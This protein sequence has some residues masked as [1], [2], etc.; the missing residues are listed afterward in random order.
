MLKRLIVHTTAHGACV[1]SRFAAILIA[2]CFLV[3]IVGFSSSLSGVLGISPDEGTPLPDTTIAPP[4][5][6]PT[7]GPEGGGEAIWPPASADMGATPVES[8]TEYIEQ[9]SVVLPGTPSLPATSGTPTVAT[10]APP[11]PVVTESPEQIP[12]R[13][14][15]SAPTVTDRAEAD[16]ST[17]SAP[18]RVTVRLVARDDAFTPSS[19]TVPAGAEVT[20]VLENEDVDTPHNVV[21]YADRDAPLFV[22]TIVKGPGRTTD[23]FTAPSEPGKYVL[24][25]CMPSTHRMGIFVVE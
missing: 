13:T 6:S 9:D 14:P 3:G 21:V 18:D 7:T 24:G 19:I 8:P 16:S 10:S 11:T 17:G 1:K 5:D 12:S 25:C 15:S 23:T 22:G 2:L 20:I 4:T